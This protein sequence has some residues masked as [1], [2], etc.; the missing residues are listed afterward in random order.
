MLATR[1][2]GH[3]EAH[4]DEAVVECLARG[5]G[6]EWANARVTGKSRGHW[7]RDGLFIPGCEVGD[8][9]ERETPVCDL[10]NV[11]SGSVLRSM[12]MDA[13]DPRSGCLDSNENFIRI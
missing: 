9:S 13:L 6:M 8:C 7:A 4:K 3:T 11:V 5:T 1:Y 2:F 10:Q 12:R